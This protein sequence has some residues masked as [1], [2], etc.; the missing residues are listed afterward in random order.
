MGEVMSDSVTHRHVGAPGCDIDPFSDDFL[1]DPFPFL[2]QLRE[3]GPVVYLDRY[4]VYAVARHEQVHAVL[5]E[6]RVFSSAAGGGVT[7]IAA[8]NPW[9][10]TSSLAEVGAPV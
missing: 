1:A 2:D 4:G 10:K 5:R 3:A 7:N 6:P 9:R 8:E